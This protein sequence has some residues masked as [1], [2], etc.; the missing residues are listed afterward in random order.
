MDLLY[1]TIQATE[2]YS[3]ALLTSTVLERPK[4]LSF[5]F[6]CSAGS[7]VAGHSSVLEKTTPPI[8][9]RPDLDEPGCKKTYLETLGANMD[10]DVC[11]DVNVYHQVM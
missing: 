2:N 11:V 10:V 5:S 7:R 6:Y 1:L 4:L 8:L 9:F 3:A